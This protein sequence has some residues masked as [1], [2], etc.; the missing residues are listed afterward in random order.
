M[1]QWRERA[2]EVWTV[3]NLVTLARLPLVVG[4]VVLVDSPVRY[5]LF[6]L[7]VFSDGFDGWL[8]RRLDQQTELGALLDPALDK[9]TALVLVAALFPRTDLAPAYL[10]LF[11][12]R[13]TF[14]VALA[15]LV[16]LYGFDTDRIK[17][18]P[19]GKVVTNL[20]FLAIVALLVPAPLATEGLLWALGAASAL[21]VADYTVFV[22]REL[23]D[24]AWVEESWGVAAVYA[25]VGAAFAAV[26][27]L[28]LADELTAFLGA[29]AG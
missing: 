16:P 20:Q 11:F 12:A 7:V 25:V 4:I 3:P 1:T 28:V 19:L 21:A 2:G 27:A 10:V 14:V 17:A 8:A 29:V 24:A 26:V 5:V 13:D 18:R 6:A 23:T 9:V 22:V 15:P